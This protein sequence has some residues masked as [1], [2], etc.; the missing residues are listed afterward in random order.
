MAR[1]FTD[2]NEI[3]R[4]LTGQDKPKNFGKNQVATQEEIAKIKSRLKNP[5]I[6]EN[7]KAMLRQKLSELEAA[8]KEDKPIS[9]AQV[10]QQLEEKLSE[11]QAASKED[12]PSASKENAEEIAKLKSRLNNPMIDEAAKSIV[13]K[14]LEA[15]EGKKSEVAPQ[16][17]GRK[18]SAPAKPKFVKKKEKEEPKAAPKKRGRKPSTTPKEKP[19]TTEPKVL[20]KRGRKPKAKPVV[21]TK[22][23]VKKTYTPIKIKEGEP[24]CDTLL[25]QFRERRRKAKTAQRKRKTTPV[26]RKISSDVIDAVEKALKNVP[27]KQFK[28][29][30]RETIRKFGNLKKSAEQ[31]LKAFKELLGKEYQVTESQKEIGELKMLIDKLINKYS[32]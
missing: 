17:R 6:D 27:A 14:K 21:A 32:K 23:R 15:L 10:I 30:P 7:A 9:T 2:R 16:K 12:K 19:T 24:D 8:S 29:S 26:F 1:T 20:K 5:M 13:R 11:L 28:E 31:F 18:P 22:P 4:Y 3:I 25:T